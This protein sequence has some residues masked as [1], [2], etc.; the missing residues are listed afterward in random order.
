MVTL[1]NFVLFFFFFY[2][3]RKN[4]IRCYIKIHSYI[5]NLFES[6]E[7]TE[8]SFIKSGIFASIFNQF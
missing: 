5:D 4:L 2:Q 3:C 6:T 1:V 7:Y 8:L